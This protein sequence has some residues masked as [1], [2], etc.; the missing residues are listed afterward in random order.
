MKYAVMTHTL[1]KQAP[2]GKADIEQVC[3]LAA[4]LGLMAV[5]QIGLYG[6]DPHDI[7]KMADHYGVRIICYTFPADLNFPDAASRQRGLDAIRRGLEAAAVLGA[8]DIMLPFSAKTEYSRQEGRRNIIA[9]LRDAIA[10]GRKAGIYVSIE[11]FPK[12]EAPFVVASEVLEATDAVPDLW[13]TFDSGNVFTG[14]DDPSQAFLAHRDRLRHVHFKDWHRLPPGRGR[15]PGLDGNS[16]EDALIGE[17]DIDYPALLRTM[18]ASGYDRYIDIEYTG[19]K[20]SGEEATRRALDYLREVESAI[21]S[22]A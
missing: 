1:A 14:G 20:Y 7:R 22:P 17:G 6:Y 10:L 12:A 4:E 9:G 18:I 13:V 19:T 16:Y 5:D 11:H 15:V 2:D 3:R 21:L 8:E